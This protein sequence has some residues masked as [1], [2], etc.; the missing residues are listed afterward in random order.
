MK[1]IIIVSLDVVTILIT[2]AFCKASSG[3]DKILQ[4]LN[5]LNIHIK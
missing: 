3:A 1:E 4:N 2:L 5:E